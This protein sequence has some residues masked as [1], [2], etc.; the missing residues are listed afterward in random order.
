MVISWAF[1]IGAADKAALDTI[2]NM[3][4][5]LDYSIEENRVLKELLEEATGKKRV[6]VRDTHRRRLAVKAIALNIHVLANIATIFQPQT[7][8]RW[9]R[10]LVR[11][12]YTKRS[13]PE[14]YRTIS[15]EIV[16][17][18][19][20]VAKNNQNWG[21]QR[22][23]DMMKY[24]GFEISTSTVRRILNEHGISPSPQHKP[25]ITWN[26]FI[27]SHWEVLTATDFLS[28]EL[29]TL[30]GLMRCM[31]LF[32]VDIQTR[33]VK[34]VGVK[35]N[36]DGAWV[37]QVAR[38]MTDPWDGFLL[39]EKYLICDRDSLFT[40]DVEQI[41]KERGIKM[42]RITAGA[43]SMNC[44]SESFVKTIKHECLNKMIFLSERQVKY[45]VN[46]FLS[47]YNFERVHSGLDGE[48]PN[49]IHEQPLDGKIIEF[50]RLGGMLKTYR[51]V[52]DEAA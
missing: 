3:Q 32:F 31:I 28:V 4:K 36:P 26:E 16:N 52:Y 8:L 11:K 6:P 15:P 30:L 46:E 20:R 18:V 19:L 37:K 13:T 35:I 9:H 2:E 34:L 24:L 25:N 48:M 12:K 29:L 44:Y 38:N 41:F 10:D 47:H 50:S 23:R 49:D 14:H 42:K 40:M 33:T 21:Y 17:E 45:A 51:R 39:G 43:P 22:I 7:L 1:L 27:K 5:A